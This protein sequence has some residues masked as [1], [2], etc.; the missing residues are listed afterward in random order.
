MA[1]LPSWQKKVFDVLNREDRCWIHILELKYG[2]LDIGPTHNLIRP[3]G[4]ITCLARVLL[5]LGLT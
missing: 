3:L 5:F 1:E 4:F 2:K